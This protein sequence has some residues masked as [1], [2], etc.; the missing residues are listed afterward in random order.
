MILTILKELASTDSIN[1][2]QAIIESQKDNEV[3]KRVFL[4]A[5][6]KRFNYGIKKWSPSKSTNTLKL[7]EVLDFLEF[8]LARRTISGHAA[9]HKFESMQAS[10]S[11]DDAEV[12]RRVMMRDLECGA[13]VTLPNRV[14]K[15]LIPEQPQMLASSY[16]KKDIVKNIKFPAYAQLK[17]DGARCFAEITD[18]GVTFYSRA[19]NEYLG[20]DLLATQL[21]EMTVAARLL[22][23]EGVMI[24]GELVYYKAKAKEENSLEFM[25]EDNSEQENI[26]E[27]NVDR[28][29]SNG[30]A[31]KSLK[32]TLSKNESLGMKFQVWDIVP[33]ATVYGT[34]KSF[35]YDVRF[36]LLENTIKEHNPSQVILIENQVVHNLDE[37][38]DIYAKYRDQDL[39][40]II[41]KNRDG[42]W[43]NKRSK[44]Q[45]KFKAVIDI[46]MEIVGYYEHSKDPSKLGGVN[47]A[48]KCR[49]ITSDCGSGFTD[50]YRKKIDGEWIS[51][52]ISDR[53]ELDREALMI[54]AKAGRLVGRIADCEC[55]GW[56]KSKGRKD[57]TVGLFLPIIKGFRFDK[58]EADTFESVFGDFSKTGLS[59]EGT[60]DMPGK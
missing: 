16:N 60:N 57:K 9:I 30:L 47:I 34:Q 32:G 48:S 40:G 51:I 24:D 4:M 8:E 59:D 50:T 1:K 23:P 10:L 41:L 39:E 26:I 29:T 27:S 19:G 25:F 12:I 21:F 3:L 17:A 22:H 14:W 49:R 52:P 20:L 28:S 55:N 46:A 36:M 38:Y 58:S 53:S 5:Y 7:E 43:E 13:G 45:Y 11:E 54:E 15:N 31:N 2:K 44:N 18:D 42:L 35:K 56:T 33:M 6:S 37:A